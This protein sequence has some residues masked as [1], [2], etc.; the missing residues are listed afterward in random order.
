MK[1][2][3]WAFQVKCAIGKTRLQAINGSLA[4]Q[5][6]LKLVGLQPFD[7]PMSVQELATQNDKTKIVIAYTGC[8]E[9][10][11]RKK[12]PI[13]INIIKPR[14]ADNVDILRHRRFQMT[15]HRG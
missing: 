6:A 1:V 15:E 13:G 3:D 10:A 11:R 9:I 7:L 2:S 14:C 5:M 12:S 4:I 8:R